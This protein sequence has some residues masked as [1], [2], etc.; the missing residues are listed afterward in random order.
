MSTRGSAASAIRWTLPTGFGM[1]TS[2]R[3]RS[4]WSRTP[5]H[6]RQKWWTPARRVWRSGASAGQQSISQIVFIGTQHGGESIWYG[7][8]EPG[9]N[10]RLEVWLRQKGLADDGAV[11]FSYGRGYPDIQHTFQVADQWGK[12]TF[13]FTGPPRP[14]DAWHFGHTFSFT[15]PGTLW[16]DNCRIF[17][18]YGPESVQR[19][20][21]PNF[22]VFRELMAS[23]PEAGPRGRIGSGSSTATPRCLRC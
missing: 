2:S 14:R 12:Y 6:C 20:Y 17:R 22:T 15:G 1:P 3:S 9:K 11:T 8:L 4:R 5:S 21:V 16:M 7:Q 19:P 10:Y 23:Q 18:V 13:D